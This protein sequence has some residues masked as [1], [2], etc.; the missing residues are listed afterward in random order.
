MIKI[1]AVL[2]LMAEVYGALY[3]YSKQDEWGGVC[4][5]E[6][7]KK[8][9]PVDVITPSS[10]TKVEGKF[11]ELSAGSE[12]AAKNDNNDNFV[13]ISFTK[14]I[15]YK[16]PGLNDT[17]GTVA[18]LHLHWGAKDTEGSEHWLDGKQFSA[19]CHL[20]TSYGEDGKYAVVNR[21]FKVGAEN[22]ELAKIITSSE[23]SGDARAIT[24]FNLAALYPS[25]LK[26][27][28]LYEGGLTTPGC[29]EIVHWVVVPEPLTISAEQVPSYTILHLFLLATSKICP[30]P[31]SR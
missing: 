24:G 5:S 22:P 26:S 15:T 18:Q 28:I 4:N 11:V 7:S 6:T 27:V 30:L 20:V 1:V 13:Q 10:S 31:R 8:Q 9:T 23:A 29:D 16:I 21:F 3:D 25:D 19:E 2:L 12:L 14:T 17:Q